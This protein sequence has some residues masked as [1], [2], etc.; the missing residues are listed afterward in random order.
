VEPAIETNAR[1]C[2][3]RMNT[4]QD[5]VVYLRIVLAYDRYRLSELSKRLETAKPKEQ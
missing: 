5:V 1:W 2:G 4:A 3:D